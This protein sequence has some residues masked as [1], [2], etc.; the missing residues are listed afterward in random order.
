MAFLRVSQTGMFEILK[1]SYF[2]L[3]AFDSGLWTFILALWFFSTGLDT[4]FNYTSDQ[5]TTVRT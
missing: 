1:K 4:V 5:E 2:F 3:K